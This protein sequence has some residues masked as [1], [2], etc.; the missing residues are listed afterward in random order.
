ML[1]RAAG[2]MVDDWTC[3]LAPYGPRFARFFVNFDRSCSRSAL[4]L[5]MFVAFIEVVRL[6][7]F[8]VLHQQSISEWLSPSMLAAQTLAAW[9]DDLVVS[10]TRPR[11]SSSPEISINL[12]L[13][14][15]INLPGVLASSF[16]LGMSYLM[17]SA[18]VLEFLPER[19]VVLFANAAGMSQTVKDVAKRHKDQSLF[20]VV[21][22]RTTYIAGFE[23]VITPSF[24]H[25]LFETLAK[26]ACDSFRR[27]R[28]SGGDDE[29]TT[30]GVACR[31]RHVTRLAR[32]LTD[33]GG[34]AFVASFFSPLLLVSM[35]LCSWLFA[36]SEALFEALLTLP[37]LLILSSAL[38]TPL[39]LRRLGVRTALA[40][41][42]YAQ[43][44]PLLIDGAIEGPLLH[45]VLADVIMDEM[46][47][48]PTSVILPTLSLL[49]RGG[50][51]CVAAAV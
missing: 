41:A 45:F 42:M 37:V 50:V 28:V 38:A 47:A 10:F 3:L 8:I 15:E 11:G 33:L 14:L 22:E 24:G 30:S 34:G 21:A 9:P 32:G 13:P 19:P 4:D 16:N 31:K 51:G 17:R 1:W 39:G 46:S 48:E 6:C 23:G 2:Q 35:H 25:H 36:F 49:P 27:E 7:C 43:A 44:L 26:V 29:Q 20:V 18:V 40:A 5:A 12:P